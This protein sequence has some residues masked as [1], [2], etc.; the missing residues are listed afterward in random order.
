MT[1]SLDA[2]R[3]ACWRAYIESSQRLFTRLEDDL[4]ADSD[5]SFADYHVLVLLSE[6]PGQRLRMGELADRLVFSPS[7]LTYQVTTMQ[8]R[9][10]VAKEACPADRRGSEAVLTAAG[11]LALREAAPHHLR[12]VRAHL[13]DDL[14]DA[15]VA[16]L[17]RVFERLGRRL[18]ADRTASS[19]PAD[20]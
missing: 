20:K 3:M 9:G 13:I 4:R 7:R 16:C 19:T 11:L 12:S 15:E 8:K 18:R 14:D 2:E 17:T 1:E 5:L 10:L 6:A